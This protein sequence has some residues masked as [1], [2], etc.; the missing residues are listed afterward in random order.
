MM[1]DSYLE[2][3]H[4]SIH[5]HGGK[6]SELPSEFSEN[7]SADGNTSIKSWLWNVPGFRRW[8]VTRME[9]GS[10]LQVLNSVAY[11][12]ISNDQPLMGIDLLWFGKSS[13]L[14]AILD[15]QPLIQDDEYFDR[16]FDGLKALQTRFP[17]FNNAQKMHAFDPHQYFSPWLL[18]YRGSLTNVEIVFPSLFNS[19]LETYWLLYKVSTQNISILNERQVEKLHLEYNKYSAE[20]DPA[21]GLFASYFGKSWSNRFLNQFLF[22]T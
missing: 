21:H 3:L 17:Q 13:K 6:P 16:H 10:N 12:D 14:V 4:Q 8:R 2:I 9:A 7:S 1:F 20:R 19:F 22:P 11:P 18:F 5:I 15:F